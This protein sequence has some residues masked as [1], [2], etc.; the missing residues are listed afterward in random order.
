MRHGVGVVGKSAIGGEAT[1]LSG[2]PLEVLEE[3]E[4][5]ARVGLGEPEVDAFLALCEL[6]VQGLDDLGTVG[7]LDGRGDVRLDKVSHLPTD[8]SVMRM[9][10]TPAPLTLVVLEVDM[11]MW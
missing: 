1:E 10:I 6:F 3:A 9:Y 11:M 5:A 7:R 4:V 2:G 8:F